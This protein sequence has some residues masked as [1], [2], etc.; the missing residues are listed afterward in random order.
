MESFIFCA[1]GVC[2]CGIDYSEETI[3]NINIRWNE[4]DIKIRMCKLY[5]RTLHT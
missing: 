1:V 3:R 2:S 4:H 5:A